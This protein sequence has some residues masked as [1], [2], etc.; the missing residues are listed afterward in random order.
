MPERCTSGSG[1]GGGAASACGGGAAGTGTG[2]FS[3]FIEYTSLPSEVRPIGAQLS[4]R[5]AVLLGVGLVC[6]H[7]GDEIS[8]I[9]SKSFFIGISG[10]T[11]GPHLNRIGQQKSNGSAS[12]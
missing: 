12:Q 2:K 1:A 3:H 5:A 7:A 10:E 4:M 8:R 9:A 6:A 11:C